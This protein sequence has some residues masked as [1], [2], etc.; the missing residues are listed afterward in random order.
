MTLWL[1]S[2]LG[3]TVVAARVTVD[4]AGAGDFTDIQDA[5]DSAAPGDHIVVQPGTYG[6]VTIESWSGPI[7][8]LGRPTID[9]S[10]YG[11]Q[12]DGDVRVTLIGL[13]LA[14]GGIWVGAADR[15]VH[16]EDIRITDP[17][18]GVYAAGSAQI[19]G[20]SLL[21]QGATSCG[22]RANPGHL[23]LDQV[24]IVDSNYPACVMSSSSL[25][26]TRFVAYDTTYGLY[27][28]SSTGVGTASYGLLAAYGSTPF[29]TC[30]TTD[31][32]LVDFD[33]DFVDYSDDGDASNDDLSLG[34]DS[35][36]LDASDAA[37]EEPDGSPC[38]LGHTGGEVANRVDDD[39]DGLPEDWESLHGLDPTLADSTDD[40]DGDGLDALGEWLFGTDPNDP[41][42]DSDGVA[43]LA[44]L[45]LSLDPLDGTDQ[46]PTADLQ[47]GS[48]GGFI[49]QRLVLDASGS[50]D[51]AGQPLG[52]IWS[53]PE[54][55][56]G[57]SLDGRDLSGS[58]AFI[59]PDAAGWWTVAVTV[60]DGTWTDRAD[61]RFYVHEDEDVA[62]PDDFAT[63]DELLPLLV[64]GMVVE[65][66]EGDWPGDLELE[67]DV[68]FQGQ[69]TEATR[70]NGRITVGGTANVRLVELSLEAAAGDGEAP[71]EAR[72]VVQGGWV[73]VRDV[74]IATEVDGIRVEAGAVSGWGLDVEAGEDALWAGGGVVRLGRSRLAAR[75]YGAY[76][77]DTVVSLEG[78]LLTSQYSAGYLQYSGSR[79]TLRHVTALATD[80]A[81]TA[82]LVLYE[83]PA[84]LE[85]TY[86]WARDGSGLTCNSSAT[87]T[88]S[89]L[90]GAPANN[91][92]AVLPWIVDDTTP[93]EDGTLH[94][95]SVAK[96]AGDIRE[97]TE[98]GVRPDLGA[99]AGRLALDSTLDLADPDADLDQ[100]GIAAST[101][102][103][104]GTEDDEVDS[105][106]DGLPDILELLTG[107]DPADPADHLPTATVTHARVDPGDDA[108]LDVSWT[109]DPDGDTCAFA[110]DDGET[111]R[112]R[113]EPASIAGHWA[114]PW[115]LTC[116]GGHLQ[117]E[118][119]MLVTEDLR[120]PDDAPD[121]ATALDLAEDHH[122]VLLPAGVHTG[123]IDLRDRWTALEGVGPET[124]LDDDVWLGEGSL[125]RVQVEGALYTAGGDVTA[126][127][128]HGGPWVAHGGTHRAVLLDGP[129]AELH[130]VDGRNLTVDGDAYVDGQ[131]LFS[132][133]FAGHLG[134]VA[135]S[136]GQV[137]AGSVQG[138]TAWGLGTDAWI[139]EDDDPDAAILEPWP[140]SDLWDAGA[141]DVSDVDGSREDVG[142]TGGPLAWPTDGD[143][144]GL[145][146]AWEA[147][148]G[149]SD[150][151][152][153]PDEDLLD[154][155]A[156]FTA[157]TDPH[158][159]D[160]DDDGLMDGVD[161]E[162]RVTGQVPVTARLHV[163][164]HTPL[165]GQRVSA[166]A[167]AS[168]AAGGQDLDFT[169]SLIAPQ[170][171][172]TTL[173]DDGAEAWFTADVL[174]TWW[175]TVVVTA[176]DY[177]DTAMVRVHTHDEV[178]VPE[179]ADLQDFIDISTAGAVLVLEEDDYKGSIEVDK[180]LTIRS[181]TGALDVT[182]DGTQGRPA[183][184]VMDGAHLT[185]QEVTIAI[186]EDH[187]G[188]EVW[189]GSQVSLR[190]VRLLGGD[191]AFR[192][193][194]GAIEGQSV[195]ALGGLHVLD[196]VSGTLSLRNAVLG[197]PEDSAG[198]AFDLDEGTVRIESS[199]LDWRT[200]SL[201][202]RDTVSCP[203]ASCDAQLS[204]QS[205]L[206]PA[207][208]AAFPLSTHPIDL[209]WDEPQF[210][211]DP[212]DAQWLGGSDLRLAHTSAA[213]DAGIDWDPDDDGSPNDI[214]AYGGAWGN[215]PDVDNDRDGF[216][217]YDGDCDD[218]DPEVLGDPRQEC[219]SSGRCSTG[220]TP[221]TGLWLGLLALV[222]RRRRA[223]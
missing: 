199:I 173:G 170:E 83:E 47:V 153:D 167:I 114:L 179:D 158:D 41:D 22:L 29:G 98:A 169:W 223:R 147:L 204:I 81:A 76:A 211:L 126:V 113:T 33:P 54:K 189:D 56:D 145:N 194:D 181:L 34:P 19:T 96:R 55:P 138:I 57:S 185:L 63:L 103:V 70:L 193:V 45:E 9:V 187:A 137:H 133:V 122:R 51:P 26:L 100:D 90:G 214:G 219:S 91:C 121:L 155:L 40:F 180:D 166:T 205:S 120:V 16:L 159:P 146:D 218:R 30:Y 131:A 175:L 210:L 50:S 5:I 69:G 8:G 163:D 75:Y 36:A 104:L 72:L 10:G 186:E 207:G 85:Q 106:G 130:E 35:A 1:A 150:P 105:D 37:C 21:V 74:R 149:V 77:L 4:S 200:S 62:L 136:S 20:S 58:T 108:V 197:Y 191:S 184:R 80:P 11:V 202:W 182:I 49:D 142:H 143:S 46:R 84:H 38:D 209:I 151:A 17:S 99:W 144:D 71:P 220:P 188:L 171:S 15:G 59:L 23:D 60:D 154:N 25:T 92:Y 32:L 178:L 94:L 125:T 139:L 198:A 157:G 97:A 208:E 140:G 78:A 203:S 123:P 88:G 107:D 13:D 216:S 101:E 221:I 109:S 118:A 93:G 31:H 111:A 68:T 212:R 82:G 129:W 183:V 112:P 177:S 134:A 27:C 18:Q 168:S 165:Q 39:E 152:D 64:D 14:N 61:V 213:I 12:I 24:T 67:V 132:S 86:S 102:W 196:Q 65:L 148:H 127:R 176:G 141:A 161:P 195:V 172:Q 206:A 87:V 124:R 79:T 42:S 162:P 44:E 6:M 53:I 110:W 89:Y 164:R 115:T 222:S 160:T 117:G 215:W 66:G 3:G 116:G 7:L 73:D 192:L 43:D 174:G 2:A 190:R 95:D 201:Y 156:E 28:G 217:E 128:A 135:D 52:Y 48:L 119:M